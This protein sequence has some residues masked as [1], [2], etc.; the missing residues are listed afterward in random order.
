M[1]PS[2][3]SIRG[4]PCVPSLAD[5]PGPVD[6]VAVAVPAAGVPAVVAEAARLGCGGAVVVS[7]GFG[8]VASGVGLEREVREAAAS[9]P[10]PVCGPNGNG[11]VSFA[12]G[13]AIWGDS[14]QALPAGPV[15]LISQSGN[16][17]VNALGSRRGIGF[18]TVVSTGNGAVCDAT[19][20][21]LAIAGRE[22]VGSIALFL[23][24][25]GDGAKLAEGLARCAE[26][27][28][29]VAVLK[30]GSSEAG[31]GAAAAHTGA[32]A[33]DQRIFRC[34]IEE[35]GAAWARNPHELLELA[36]VLGEPRARPR[37]DGGLAVLTCSGGDSGIAADEAERLD[38]AL[39]PLTE[40]TRARLRAMLPEA[41]TVA[42]PLDYTS[43][44]WAET[45]L[46]R[47]IVATVGADPG[48]DQ[49]LVFHDTPEELSAEA[50][51]SWGATRAG[52]AAGLEQSAA[53]PLLAST[54]PDLMNETVARELAGQGIAAVSGLSTALLCARELRRSP[55]D[56]G[57][58]REIAAAAL[59]DGAD[60]GEWLGEVASKHLL[61]KAGIPVP[62]GLVV[63][64]ADSAARAAEDLGWPV[65]LKLSS[66]SI[67]HKSEAGALVLGL[68]DPAGV[69]AAAERLLTLPAAADAELLIESMAT[70]GVELIIAARADAVVPALVIGL[71]G[72]WTEALGD[73]AVVPLP[74][75]PERIERA[76][77][78]LRGA[79]LLTGG[80]GGPAVDLRAVAEVASRIGELLI[81]E[82]LEM[83]ELN[84]LIAGPEG[85][86]AVDAIARRA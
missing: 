17:A 37:G 13:M 57:R 49:L 24:S 38:L 63:A 1:N 46:L 50:T 83:I 11:V 45:E 19:D 22:G 5:L 72:I 86:M 55:A 44:L 21:L 3:E 84:P 2:R 10:M 80:R 60:E 61:R 51:E 71:G 52:I 33:G 81:S 43:L 75:P 62:S 34:L 70:P 77:R 74:A 7:A 28:I 53:A 47:D 69:L 42:N 40:V 39:P 68:A 82:K 20:W 59:P 8:E 29:G 36:R 54:L 67:Q 79:T 58:L 56:A 64:D 15:A 9:G 32:L 76:L 14:V 73:V 65:A 66:P 6:A 35:A 85:C 18:H 25:D 27:G 16:V 41:A 30:V 26:R 12:E 48:I 23:E 78:T 4:I 31:A